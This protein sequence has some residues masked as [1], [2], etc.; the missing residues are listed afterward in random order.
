MKTWKSYNIDTRAIDA[1]NGWKLQGIKRGGHL[2]GAVDFPATWLDSDHE[3]KAN[4][5]ST[6]LRTKGIAPHRH[7]LLYGTNKRDRDRV[8]DYL[9]KAGY[10][11]L[12][13]F[14]LNAWA[15]DESKP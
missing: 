3:D 10:R 6:A 11:N 4:I 14:D 9:R 8:A 15:N 7:I 13:D 5:L 1:Y 2:P 12:Y